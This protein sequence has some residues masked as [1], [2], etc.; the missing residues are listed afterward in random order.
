MRGSWLWLIEIEG[1]GRDGL[2]A[3]NQRA[4]MPMAMTSVPFP[5]DS[6]FASGVS[7]SRVCDDWQP[8]LQPGSVKLS[9]MSFSPFAGKPGAQTITFDLALPDELPEIARFFLS[10]PLPVANITAPIAPTD[11]TITM[12]DTSSL[13]AG[14]VIFVG[15]EAFRVRTVDSG[16]QVTINASVPGGASSSGPTLIWP[17]STSVNVGTRGAVGAVGVIGAIG[18]RIAQHDIPTTDQPPPWPDVRVFDANPRVKGRRVYLRRVS[19]GANFSGAVGYREQL[20]GQFLID[21]VTVNSDGTTITVKG[22][23]LVSG[24]GDQQLGARG[25]SDRLRVIQ[26][27]AGAIAQIDVDTAPDAEDRRIWKDTTVVYSSGSEAGLFVGSEFL[28]TA[29]LNGITLFQAIRTSR[30]LGLKLFVGSLIN[31]DPDTQEEEDIRFIARETGTKVKEVLISD[32]LTINRDT[33][34][35][36]TAYPPD[37]NAHPYYSVDKP[38]GAGILSHPF[39]LLLA[40]LGQ[41]ESN[42]PQH[43]QIRLDRNAVATASILELAERFAVSEWPGVCVTGP[44]KKALEWLSETFLRPLACGWVVDE[45]GRLS[46]ASITIPRLSPWST[47]ETFSGTTSVRSIGVSVLQPGR[48]VQRIIE[49][50]AGVTQTISGQGLGKEPRLTIQSADAYRVADGDPEGATFVLDAMGALSPDD[51][52]GSAQLLDITSIMFLRSITSTVGTYLRSGAIQYTLRIP[53]SFVEEDEAFAP[54]GGVLGPAMPSRYALPGSAVALDSLVPGLRKLAGPRLCVVLEQS[55]QDDCSTQQIRILDL[56]GVVRIAAAGRVVSASVVSGSLEI[57]LE[58][59]FE[60]VPLPYD[61]PPF[62]NITEDGETLSAF[63][64]LTSNPESVR[65]FDSTLAERNPGAGNEEQV[66]S[67]DVATNTLSTTYSGAYLP[68]AGDF[69]LLANQGETDV[70][71]IFAYM[72]RDVF[73]L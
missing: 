25:V 53:S 33:T 49:A 63:V 18:T 72:G 48:Q 3:N 5:G 6:A 1:L 54:N 41:L 26:T 17:E 38:G 30:T 32:P 52:T 2:S 56:G 31:E 71:D 68:V 62:V 10:Q 12:T 59:D 11:N 40:H 37:P 21:G 42:L 64:L 73:N 55:W 36:E 39:H 27:R 70:D 46:V 50:E 34:G 67:Y 16:T 51:E 22:T 57:V 7:S 4:A 29:V 19:W 20:F 9:A 58:P 60:V 66:V 28:G 15:A 8:V 44:I 61:V 24:Y 23:S 69:V 45:F 65:F 13:S 14:D 35:F 47:P 43:W